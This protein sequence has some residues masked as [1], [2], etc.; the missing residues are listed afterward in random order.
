MM[1]ELQRIEVSDE[2]D[3][4]TRDPFGEP[5]CEGEDDSDDDD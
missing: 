3:D 5:M 2:D 1:P 4:E